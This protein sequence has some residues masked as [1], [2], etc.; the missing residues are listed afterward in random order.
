MF[1]KDPPSRWKSLQNI[2]IIIVGIGLLIYLTKL[3]NIG[4]GIAINRIIN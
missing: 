4:L 2:I 3:L 1:E